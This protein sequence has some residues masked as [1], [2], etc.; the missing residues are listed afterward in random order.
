MLQARREVCLVT[1]L[2]RRSIRK[3]HGHWLH[4]FFKV[5]AQV[6][7]FTC[8]HVIRYSIMWSRMQSCDQ[9]CN[10]VLKYA[11]TWSCLLS[12]DQ[13][14]NYVLK[15]AITWSC[16]YHVIR[17]TIMCSSM[18]SHDQIVVLCW[19]GLPSVQVR[20]LDFHIHVMRRLCVNFKPMTTCLLI[21]FSL[22]ANIRYLANLPTSTLCHKSK[23]S[24]KN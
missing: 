24:R 16:C 2:I 4:G 10:H 1:G 17:Y 8:N 11:I 15:Y 7:A 12:C 13:V 5:A 20:N 23:L 9:V 19:D 21:S 14:Y 22:P 3:Q 18:Q 6:C